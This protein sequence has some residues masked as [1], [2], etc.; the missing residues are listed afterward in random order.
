MG[1]FNAGTDQKI[2]APD[3]F[4]CVELPGPANCFG[5]AEVAYGTKQRDALITLL[6]NDKSQ[7]MSWPTLLK[8]S[9]TPSSP[10]LTP[11]YGSPMLDG[12]LGQVSVVSK[13]IAALQESHDAS[14]GTDSKKKKGA[15]GGNGVSSGKKDDKAMAQFDSILPPEMPTSWVQCELCRKW[16]RVAWFVNSEALPDLWECHMN[17]WDIETATCAAPQDGY[18]PEAENTL[19]FGTSEVV[20]DEKNFTVGKKFD[21]W[22]NRNLVYYEAVV[23][24]LKHNAKKPKD[25]P[26]ALFRFVGWGARYDELVLIDSDRIQPHNLHT[27]PTCSNPREQERWQGRKDLYAD[28]S[29]KKPTPTIPVA[30]GKGKGKGDKK[31]EDSDDEAVTAPPR[32]RKTPTKTTTAKPAAK[33]EVLPTK[34]TSA[35]SAKTAASAAINKSSAAMEVDEGYADDFEDIFDSPEKEPPLPL[36]PKATS[37]SNKTA[38]ALSKVAGEASNVTPGSSSQPTPATEK[39]RSQPAVSTVREVSPDP[40]P[41]AALDKAARL[42]KESPHSL[43]APPGAGKKD[44]RSFFKHGGSTS[45]D[46][47]VVHGSPKATGSVP[48]VAA[49]SPDLLSLFETAYSV[50]AEHTSKTSVEYENENRVAE[51]EISAARAEFAEHLELD[52]THSP[53]KK[54][55]LS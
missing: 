48:V 15:A 13:V 21:L 53:E 26:K 6:G 35:R 23:I 9:F 16:R 18:D 20:V 3:L 43:L 27:N 49:L 22:C 25:V 30:K 52:E 42:A 54:A 45:K 4:G 8:Q 40:L 47:P 32:K 29:T 31:E 17:T 5:T 37:S 50:P 36:P 46:V 19:G 24:K 7:T 41:T 44:I 39:V 11:L 34:K 55:R 28:V 2:E 51:A 38:P 1:W 12:A 33:T 10:T 14:R